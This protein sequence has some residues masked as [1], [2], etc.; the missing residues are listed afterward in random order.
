[1]KLATIVSVVAAILLAV[2]TW[3]YY[4]LA[5]NAQNERDELKNAKKNCL[6]V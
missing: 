4:Q 6:H 2:T 5:S 3:Y 1:M